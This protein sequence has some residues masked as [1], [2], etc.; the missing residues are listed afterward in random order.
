[1][2]TMA[3]IFETEDFMVQSAEFPLVDRKDG[4]HITIDPRFKISTRQELTPR[5]AIGLM[6]L[7]MIV[8]EAMATVMNNHGVDIGRINYQDNGNWSVFKPEG[9]QLHYHLY[10]RAKN[11]KIQKYGQT[12]YMPH[13]E[14]A[15]DFYKAYEKLTDQDIAAIREEIKTLMTLEKYTDQSWSL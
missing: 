4:G 13:K 5:Q 14:E 7:T 15:P 9:P 3:M 10:G 2:N 8:G 1:M 11:A 6:R 12:L